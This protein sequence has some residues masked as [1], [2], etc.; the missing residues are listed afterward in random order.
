MWSP[1]KGITKNMYLSGLQGNWK[2][3]KVAKSFQPSRFLYGQLWLGEKVLEH[4]VAR[5]YFKACSFAITPESLQEE[6]QVTLGRSLR[7]L[8]QT[9][10]F[11]WRNLQSL[12]HVLY[13]QAVS[14]YLPQQTGTHQCVL[15]T[16]S[17]SLAKLTSEHSWLSSSATRK[18]N[19]IVAFLDTSV[20]L[21]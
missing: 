21:G 17:S 11:S 2:D 4:L 18:T 8:F 9:G 12:N 16:V 13:H 20:L 15:G 1:W 14:A 6:A 7:S 19:L 5:K 3:T 10:L